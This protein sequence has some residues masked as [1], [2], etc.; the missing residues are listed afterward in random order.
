M[1]NAKKLLQLFYAGALADS[2]NY[3]SRAGIL[4]SVTEA[5]LRQQQVAAP[6]QLRQLNIN[7]PEE[8]FSQFSEIFGCIDWKVT[9]GG[10]DIN[11][12]G[13]SCLLCSIAKRTGTS[14]PCNIYCINPFRSLS[15]AMDPSY[16]LT[17]KET[18]WEGG[19]CEFI[20]EKTKKDRNENK[21]F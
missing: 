5:K 8:L 13:E 21:K 19:K 18:L 16:S 17:V 15:G 3:Y 1:I 12:Y 4:E 20:L 6:G 7:T 10:E 14:Q 9:Q 2:V 11:A